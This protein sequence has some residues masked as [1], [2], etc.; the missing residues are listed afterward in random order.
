MLPMVAIIAIHNQMASLEGG[1][2]SSGWF[3][4]GASFMLVEEL[5]GENSV[6][7]SSMGESMKA[8]VITGICAAMKER[9]MLA[10]ALPAVRWGLAV[11]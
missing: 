9:S 4:E 8:P 1:A 5:K 11:R 10:A 3:A 7:H 6:L 2:G